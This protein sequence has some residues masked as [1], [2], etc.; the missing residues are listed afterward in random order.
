MRIFCKSLLLFALIFLAAYVA[1]ILIVP[2]VMPVADREQPDWQIQVAFFFN[3]VQ[4]IGLI[5]MA[6]VML[7]ALLSQLKS[8]V[9]R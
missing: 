1:R 9:A 6:V 5:G 2:N 4:N 7:L 3:S 8:L